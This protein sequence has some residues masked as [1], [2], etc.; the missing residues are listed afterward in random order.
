MCNDWQAVDNIDVSQELTYWQ[1]AATQCSAENDRLK[2]E[3]KTATDKTA[4]DERTSVV[5]TDNGEQT[6][7]VAYIYR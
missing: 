1:K 3:L 5:E 7:K 6:N 2:A 4:K